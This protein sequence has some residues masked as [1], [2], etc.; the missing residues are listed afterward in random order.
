[1][2]IDL[3]E[4]F[5]KLILADLREQLEIAESYNKYDDDYKYYKKLKK[6]LKRVVKYYSTPE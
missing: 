4:W 3:N 1:M 5:Y 2:R 6:A